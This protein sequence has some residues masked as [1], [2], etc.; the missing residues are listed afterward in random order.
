MGT[1]NSRTVPHAQRIWTFRLNRSSGWVTSTT[2]A[3]RVARGC[4][5]R[6]RGAVGRASHADPEAAAAVILAVIVGEALVEGVQAANAHSFPRSA[7]RDD[8]LGRAPQLRGPVWSEPCTLGKGADAAGTT[9]V[10]PSGY[11]RNPCRLSIESG[12]GFGRLAAVVGC[13]SRPLSAFEAVHGD[14]RK[15]DSGLTRQ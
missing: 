2:S 10:E 15:R 14:A 9:A 6:S 1:Q 13:R 7:A 3:T 8:D 4:D 12:F 5:S 11:P